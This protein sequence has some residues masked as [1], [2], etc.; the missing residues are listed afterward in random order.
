MY[1]YVD[2]L[3]GWDFQYI[4]TERKNIKIMFYVSVHISSY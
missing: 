1:E 4:A 3:R 2:A